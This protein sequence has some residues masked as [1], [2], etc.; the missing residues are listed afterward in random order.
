MASLVPCGIA[1]PL[2]MNVE[3]DFSRSCMEAT[4]DWST[5][6]ASTSSWPASSMAASR[7][8]AVP[9][10]TI[11]LGAQHVALDTVAA[12]SATAAPRRPGPASISST[13][14]SYLGLPMKLSTDT[15]IADGVFCLARS[16]RSW[17][18][19]TRS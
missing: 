19:T 15:W 18:V 2:P 4:Y 17:W 7:S 14:S 5:A 1:S 8:A 16:V 6:P 3:T 11:E 10:S 13:I 9:P 12:S